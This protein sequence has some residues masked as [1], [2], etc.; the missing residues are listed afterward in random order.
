MMD[1]GYLLLEGGGEFGGQMAEPDLKAIELAGG[2]D[3]PISILPAAAAPDG[4]HRRAGQNGLRWFRR[5]GAS[6]VAVLPL[7]DRVS[8][9][10]P[11]VVQALRSSRLI[12]LLGGFPGHLCQS[13][14]GSQ[15]WGAILSAYRAGAVIAGSSAGAMVLCQHFYD[16][17]E[18]QVKEGL[19]LL[20][21][22]CVLPHHNAFG[23][24][25]AEK[26]KGLLPLDTLLG[27]DEQTGM[28]HHRG[29]DLWTVHGKGGVTIYHREEIRFIPSGTTFTFI[30]NRFI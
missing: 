21:D 30:R 6:Q 17:Y 23:R 27:I 3:A 5:L 12:Y 26:L 7:V 29:Q 9:D 14:A 19:N 2:F 15:S 11:E 25:W 13:L 10:L 22:V 16:P 18:D 20:P 28:I 8:A 1:A 24:R 4:N